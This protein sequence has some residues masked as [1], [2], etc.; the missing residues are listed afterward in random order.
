MIPRGMEDGDEVCHDFEGG[1]NP[2]TCAVSEG[3][4]EWKC[5][6]TLSIGDCLGGAGA[7]APF[8]HWIRI[9]EGG[10]LERD[11]PDRVKANVRIT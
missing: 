6:G 4:L 8:E 2:G 10:D 3:G 5:P 1:R 11:L 7:V 9:L